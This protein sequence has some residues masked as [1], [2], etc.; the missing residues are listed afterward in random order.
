MYELVRVLHGE[1]GERRAV[2]PAV[3]HGQWVL[4]DHVQVWG[5]CDLVGAQEVQVALHA[6]PP[7]LPRG[8]G[9]PPA[10]RLRHIEQRDDVVTVGVGAVL[11]L[12]AVGGLAILGGRQ[13]MRRI[14][15]PSPTAP[16]ALVSR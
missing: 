10:G 15:L 3:P 8:S 1:V 12:W 2:D 16:R 5:Q 6:G 11:S 7:T 14:P 4:A 9:D 13:L